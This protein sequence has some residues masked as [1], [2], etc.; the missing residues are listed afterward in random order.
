MS[1]AR[2]L[3][4]E[5]VDFL[6]YGEIAPME[7]AQLIG[8]SRQIA[9]QRHMDVV[10]NNM[11]NVNTTGFKNEDILFE[12]Y[13]M[14]VASDETFAT[15]DQDLSYTQDWATVH[16]LTG[17]AIQQ[18][19]N[20]LDIALEGEGFLTVMTPAGERYTRNGE[21]KLDS[22]GLLVNNEG[23]AVLSEGGEV[24]FSAS[25][26]GI[27]FGTDGSILTSAGSK[28]RLAVVSFENPQ[29]LKRDGNNLFSGEGAIQDL[30][31]RTVQGAVERSNVSGITEMANMIRVNRAYQTLA[32]I[33]QRQEE[34]RSDAIQR[35]GDLQA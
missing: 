34:L 5:V 32:Q 19:G 4:G 11:A 3:P 33:M 24:R 7:N 17:G 35:L 10:A 30:T 13:I 25:E 9:L 14:P 15:A 29:A 6:K 18:T 31:T 12:E 28:G 21:L 8:L 1:R 20:T 2:P 22:T 26:T 23:Y 27:S 16:D